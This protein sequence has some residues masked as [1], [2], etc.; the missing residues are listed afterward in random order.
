MPEFN[1]TWHLKNSSSLTA[2]Q[3]SSERLA[4]ARVL[5]LILYSA[6]EY[7]LNIF[8][9]FFLCMQLLQLLH[10][11]HARREE[12]CLHRAPSHRG[13]IKKTL[14]H[15]KTGGRKFLV[16]PLKDGVGK[17]K[18]EAQT[19]F[20]QTLPAA[21]SRRSH[22][23]PSHGLTHINAQFLPPEAPGKPPRS[24]GEG[25]LKA[26]ATPCSRYQGS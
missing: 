7:K 15:P 20:L 17:S 8:R 26:V 13:G 12:R 18:G 25:G 4:T 5:W 3:Q 23:A 24:G 10:G 9:I 22:K 11:C 6:V 2:A 19:P 21:T 16:K 1:G 14:E